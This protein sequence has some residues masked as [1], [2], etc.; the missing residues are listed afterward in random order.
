MQPRD[1]LIKL[2]NYFNS[3]QLYPKL[4]IFQERLHKDKKWQ[5]CSETQKEIPVYEEENEAGEERGWQV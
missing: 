2:I 4:E 3:K 1:S 5:N